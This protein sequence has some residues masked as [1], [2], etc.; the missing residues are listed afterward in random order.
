MASAVGPPQQ[1]CR[2]CTA[3]RIKCDLV[4]PQCTPCQQAGRLCTG[5]GRAFVFAPASTPASASRRHASAHA[6]STPVT[7]SWAAAS[8]SRT[9]EQ[10]RHVGFFWNVYL[11]NG[12][13]FPD[14][15]G[16]YT[17]CGWT[18]VARDI[19]SR[20][21]GSSSSDVNE[22]DSASAVVR[23]AIVANSLCMFG[24]QHR[25]ARMTKDGQQAYG[26]ALLKMRSTLQ[27]H[28]SKAT[29]SMDDKLA[30]VIASRLLTVFTMLFGGSEPSTTSDQTTATA[31]TAQGQA[32]VGLNAGEMALVLSSRPS[33]YRAGDAHQV[34]ADTRLNLYLPALIAKSQ[35]PLAAPAWMSEP[36]SVVPKTPLDRL[37]D[38]LAQIPALARDLTAVNAACLCV[39]DRGTAD[40]R[41]RA[42]RP[43][44]ASFV[45][46]MQSWFDDVVPG[47]GVDE[48]LVHRTGKS[49]T[50]RTG[51]AAAMDLAKAHTL[52]LF[53]AICLMFRGGLLQVLTEPGDIPPAF[54]NVRAVRY[55]MLRVLANKFFLPL[56]S[57]SK[58]QGCWYS[59]NIALFPLR[60]VLGTIGNEEEG[61]E[62]EDG[63]G[64]PLSPAEREL[65][66]S[67]A[68]E[69]KARGVASFLD[70]MGR[71]V[72]EAGAK[73]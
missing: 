18:R 9:A 42:L 39:A 60:T 13:P 1:A 29:Q 28:Q 71:Y 40:A 15:A 48:L 54:V 17:T 16:H 7:Q 70:S 57:S 21:D 63:D 69:C 64:F 38:L 24:S 62:K 20:R 2:N 25:E 51:T 23:L 26:E 59:I 67:I 8:L 22:N 52:V 33:A 46:G 53:W 14:E 47:L 3:G 32:W 10:D 49:K 41:R 43:Q 55:N 72:S 27:R 44:C 45:A 68:N 65:M 31:A 6:T 73:G 61:E 35:T 34:F 50:E 66:A 36:W 4:K 19:C 5:A 11:P 58:R 56:S 37:V 30:L 12:E